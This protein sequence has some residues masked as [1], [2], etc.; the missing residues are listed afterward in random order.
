MYKYNILLSLDIDIDN[1]EILIYF[2]DI[3]KY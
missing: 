2:I 3:L 1:L